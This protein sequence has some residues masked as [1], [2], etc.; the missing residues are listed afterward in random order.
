MEADDLRTGATACVCM[1]IF[2]VWSLIDVVV[3]SMYI[4]DDCWC[5]SVVFGCLFERV[6]RLVVRSS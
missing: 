1:L 6:G 3:S 2:C 4:V 5:L